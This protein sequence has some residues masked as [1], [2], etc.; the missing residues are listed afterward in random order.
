M[1]Y[2]ALSWGL[3]SIPLSRRVILHDNRIKLWEVNNVLFI[4]FFH[5]SFIF[6]FLLLIQFWRLNR[7]MDW[8]KG[9]EMEK[10]GNNLLAL[11]WLSNFLQRLY[12]YKKITQIINR[13]LRM[14]SPHNHSYSSSF[15]RFVF[16]WSLSLNP[17]LKK[18]WT[19][20]R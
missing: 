7:R 1:G 3:K 10:R 11:Q 14:W 12:R 19:I 15:L 16:I 17:N 4:L 6:S 20:E 9:I 8:S 5:S 2:R 13:L 18:R